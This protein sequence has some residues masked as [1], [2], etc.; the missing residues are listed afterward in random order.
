MTLAILPYDSPANVN[1]DLLLWLFARQ[2]A[3]KR[4]S[5][6]NVKVILEEEGFFEPDKVSIEEGDAA[7]GRIA[8]ELEPV[9]K[10]LAQRKLGGDRPTHDSEPRPPPDAPK[11]HRLRDALDEALTGMAPGAET[12]VGNA[13]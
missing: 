9:F 1:P 7:F 13:P 6:F 3:S 8:H 2:L 10:R 12:A 5:F 11:Y 4:L